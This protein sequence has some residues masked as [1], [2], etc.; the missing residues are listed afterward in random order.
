M[1]EYN[2]RLVLVD[3]DDDEGGDEP[4]LI[5]YH[6]M[7]D[8]V[9]KQY[10][11]VGDLKIEIEENEEIL[12]KCVMNHRHILNSKYTYITCNCPYCPELGDNIC[13]ECMRTCHKGHITDN[14]NIIQKSVNITQTYCSCAEGGHKK[15]ELSEKQEIISDERITCQMLKLI[16]KE[17]II[18]YYVDRSKNKFYCPFCRKNCMPEINSKITPIPVNKLRKEE[19]HCACKEAKYH[20]KKVDDI[21][22]LQRLFIDKKN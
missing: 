19:F 1:K 14:R 16:G 4:D 18:T 3:D 17:N 15:K 8:L 10:K 11:E 5:A 20:S 7:N 6:E 12:N 9:D 2:K 22:R 21:S 13:Y